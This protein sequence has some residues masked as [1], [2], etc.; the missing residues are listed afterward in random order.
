MDWWDFKLWSCGQL[1][2]RCFSLAFFTLTN[3][4]REF[5]NMTF[6]RKTISLGSQPGLHDFHSH[7][8]DYVTLL[9]M[10]L[11]FGVGLK[12]SLALLHQG[13]HLTWQ[14]SSVASRVQY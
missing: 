12:S 4:K 3:T 5:D 9:G 13:A 10:N 14:V 6:G 7:G 8:L 1:R 11:I 2:V